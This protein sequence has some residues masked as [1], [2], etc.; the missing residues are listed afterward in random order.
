M[1]QVK[2]LNDD[3]KHFFTDKPFDVANDLNGDIFRQHENRVTKRFELE[4][5]I[6]L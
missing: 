6:T 5:K 4:Q 2:F 1:D 3:L